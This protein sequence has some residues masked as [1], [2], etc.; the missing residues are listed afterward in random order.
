M[1]RVT[2]FEPAAAAALDAATAAL[3]PLIELQEAAGSYR[4]PI[5]KYGLSQKGTAHV[6]VG[7]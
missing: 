6:L 3:R 5:L 1:V 4:P 2:G 7:V